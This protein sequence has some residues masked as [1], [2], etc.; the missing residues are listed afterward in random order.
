M[1]KLKFAIGDKDELNMAVIRSMLQSEGHLIACEETDG[2]A[3]LRKIRA[4]APDFVIVSYNMPGMK[5]LEIARIVQGDRLA[6]VLLTADSSQDIF[7]RSMGEENFPYLIRPINQVQLIGTI[8]FVYN[9][10][11]RMLELEK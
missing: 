2:P 9:S 8:D 10:F 4:V 7:I 5:G 6:P 11:K 1:D 3:L